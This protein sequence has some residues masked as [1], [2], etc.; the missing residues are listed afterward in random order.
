MSAPLEVR[1]GEDDVVPLGQMT[2]MLIR[3]IAERSSSQQGK[4]P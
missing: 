2:P 3:R 1:V 4:A